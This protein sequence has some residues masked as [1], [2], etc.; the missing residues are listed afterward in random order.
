MDHIM[1]DIETTGTDPGHSAIIQIA[2]VRF[3]PVE[4]TI[5][6]T[7]MFDRCLR[8]LPT[9]YWSES[10]REWWLKD[11]HI[12]VL[13]DIMER[14]EDPKVVFQDL[15]AWIRSGWMLGDACIWAKPIS[16][17]WPFLQSYANELDVGLPAHFRNATDLNSYIKG[18]GHWNL[19]D[20]WRGVTFDGDKHNALHDV[21]Y[22]IKG[23]ML[24]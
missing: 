12:P 16:F 19:N 14:R 11:E 15:Q 2:A 17:E 4:K 9:R 20:F 3:N 24:A 1:L 8:M 22:Q 7:S 23:A 21:M 5:D 18:R 6:T 10:T 13:R